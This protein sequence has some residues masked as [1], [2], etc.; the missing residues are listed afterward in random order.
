MKISKEQLQKKINSRDGVSYFD[1]TQAKVQKDPVAFWGGIADQRN[2]A[3]KNCRDFLNTVKDHTTPGH[4]RALCRFRDVYNYDEDAAYQDFLKDTPNERD[5][6]P[7]ENRE[8]TL[9]SKYPVK[10][11]G[12]ANYQINNSYDAGA[13]AKLKDYLNTYIKANGYKGVEDAVADFWS[14]NKLSQFD[15]QPYDPTPGVHPS[16]G[17]QAKVVY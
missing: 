7:D 14:D 2:Q 5:Q 8:R 13:M 17:V 1:Q 4:E 16:A 6:L 10:G 11:G 12:V 9:T 3:M 15:N